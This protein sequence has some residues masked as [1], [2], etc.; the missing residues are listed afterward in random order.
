[1]N[2]ETNFVMLCA[3]A[4]FSPAE[5]P[6]LRSALA[7][8]LDW[9]SIDH[10]ADRQSVSP[11]VAH[12]LLQHAGDLLPEQVIT[13]WKDKVRDITKQ[14]LIWLQEWQHLLQLLDEAAIPVISFKG[15]ALA[16]TAYGDLTLR[17]FHDLDLLVHPADMVRAKDILL[18]T[19]YTLWTPVLG[20]SEQAL[21]RSS[22]RQLRFTHP[23]RGTTVDLHWG[24]LHEMFSFQLE[25]DDVFASAKL[26]Q[27]E[28]VTF[29][30]LSPEHSLLYLCAHGA[31][32]CWAHLSEL[33]DI[34]AQV[35]GNAE[36]DW[37]ECIRLAESSGCDRLLKHA[38]LLAEHVLRIHLPEA[39]KQYCTEDEDAMSLSKTAERFLYPPTPGYWRTLQYH[40]AFAK[41]PRERAR[42]I[43]SRVFAP[44]EPD[45]DRI[46]LPRQLFFLYYLIRPLRFLQEQTTKLARSQR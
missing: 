27:R 40:L 22:N 36:L 34:A 24:L 9:Q 43:V 20:D 41:T 16:L 7:Q 39:A 18:R 46:R 21:L 11:I 2:S 14:N 19:G 13:S 44:A 30:A 17:E 31:K 26:E 32:N 12:T 37:E 6:L 5:I 10:E 25:L 35:R 23:I 45:W 1:M 29:L 8:P 15:P 3:T 28:E 42:F 4:F 38:L 33:C